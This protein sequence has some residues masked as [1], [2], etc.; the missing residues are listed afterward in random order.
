MAGPPQPPPPP[1]PPPQ[2]PEEAPKPTVPQVYAS[3]PNAERY[4]L[5]SDSLRRRQL[6]SALLHGSERTWRDRQR[7]WP[8]ALAGILL[9]A[10]V[11][12][13]ITVA[14]AFEKQQRINE[15][16]QRKQQHA[17][18]QPVLPGDLFT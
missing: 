18:V 6:R 15:E 8:A 16:K 14:N 11:I 2:K 4:L 1:A 10:V 17:L 12:A 7:V 13:A 9:V 3:T 5:E